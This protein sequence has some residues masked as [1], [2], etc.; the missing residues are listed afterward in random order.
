MFFRHSFNFLNPLGYPLRRE[1]LVTQPGGHAERIYLLTARPRG[2]H[3]GAYWCP[4]SSSSLGWPI[5]VV[6]YVDQ[7]V[8]QLGR[9]ADIFLELADLISGERHI[10]V[11]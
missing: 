8:N 11:E 5:T 4:K 6:V 9:F 1:R 2:S 3:R 10:A 7:F